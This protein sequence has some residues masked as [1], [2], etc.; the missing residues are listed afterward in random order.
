MNGE[1]VLASILRTVMLCT[2]LKESLFT[3]WWTREDNDLWGT[4]TVSL[5]TQ[6]VDGLGGEE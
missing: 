2:A 1:L 3:C 4:D 5:P 6:N